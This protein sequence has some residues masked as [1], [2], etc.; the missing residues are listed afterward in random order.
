MSGNVADWGEIGIL[1]RDL[2]RFLQ[3]RVNI[4]GLGLRDGIRGPLGIHV[5]NK[6][7][8]SWNRSKLADSPRRCGRRYLPP[9]S[10]SVDHVSSGGFPFP[11]LTFDIGSISFNPLLDRQL[12][13]RKSGNTLKPS[14]SE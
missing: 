13:Q 6:K 7:W 2:D 11:P 9:I 3:T 5:W 10:R 4:T 8:V 14:F 1:L 12:L